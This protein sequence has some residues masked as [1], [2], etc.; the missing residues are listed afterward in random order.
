MRLIEKLHRLRVTQDRLRLQNTALRAALGQDLEL[1]LLTASQVARRLLR[2]ESTPHSVRAELETIGHAATAASERLD[3]LRVADG[4]A[5]LA[6]L[7]PEPRVV[8]IRQ[9][10]A[11]VLELAGIHPTATRPMPS[12]ALSADG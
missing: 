10:V 5:P 11:E 8:S 3:Q 1:P 2:L 12:S 4:D 7:E 9:T 6:V